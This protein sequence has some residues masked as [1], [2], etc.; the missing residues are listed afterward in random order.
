MS[1]P[2]LASLALHAAPTSEMMDAPLPKRKV[3]QLNKHG[4][5]EPLSQEK[6]KLDKNYFRVKRQNHEF[7][8]HEVHKYDYF[9]FEE[10]KKAV[11]HG[12]RFNPLNPSSKLSD[13]DLKELAP[14]IAPGPDG[15][16]AERF[17]EELLEDPRPLTKER[18]QE[19]PYFGEPTTFVQR[20]QATHSV[21]AQMTPKEELTALIIAL[22]AA[23]NSERRL[24]EGGADAQ[25]NMIRILQSPEEL[26][27]DD[28]YRARRWEHTAWQMANMLAF[29]D[30]KIAGD[31][32]TFNAGKEV[33]RSG[34]PDH[35]F[36]AALSAGF[37]KLKAAL[38]ASGRASQADAARRVAALEHFADEHNIR[39][40]V[41]REHYL[42]RDLHDFT[43]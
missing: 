25:R 14:S 32:A 30:I 24:K 6:Y 27:F 4:G 35:E 2:N 43:L 5:T 22:C 19:M 34:R 15:F 17:M 1:L 26:S 20:W 11:K 40:E 28:Q 38:E 29:N 10:L 9:D 41:R 18:L 12:L 8:E 36:G 31:S 7:Y 42:L 21:R 39:Q 33:L 13:D 3:K 37:S 16:P 23:C